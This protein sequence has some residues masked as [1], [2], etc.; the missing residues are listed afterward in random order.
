VPAEPEE[1]TAL[2]Q[3]KIAAL[4]VQKAY[5]F[6]VLAVKDAVEYLNGNKNAIPKE[7]LE[8][9]VIATKSNLNDPTVKKYL[10]IEK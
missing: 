1:V 9:Y 8:T 6:G 7:T 5:D 3:G 10:Y 2:H 4:I